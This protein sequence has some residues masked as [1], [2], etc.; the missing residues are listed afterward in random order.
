MC[1]WSLWTALTCRSEVVDPCFIYCH[2]CTQKPLFVALKLL[3]PTLWIVDAFL[4]LIDCENT[5]HPLWTQLSHWQ[6]FLQNSEYSAFWY[7]QLLYYFTQLQ[8]R[9]GQNEFVEF[10]WC[11]PGH[12]RIWATWAFSIICVCTTTFKVSIPHLN[13][14]FRRS[15]VQITLIKLLLCLIRIFPSESNALSTLEIQIFPLF[16][17]LQL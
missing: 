9:I 3:L 6:I 12:C 1:L 11:F 5:R 13:R 7:L 10:F 4:F 2:I 15:R 8:L 14:C 16:E 17:N